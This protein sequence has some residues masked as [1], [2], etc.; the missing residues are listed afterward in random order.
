MKYE[1][2]IK[3]HEKDL[4]GYHDKYLKDECKKCFNTVLKGYGT[5]IAD[6]KR[7]HFNCYGCSLIKCN[8][9]EIKENR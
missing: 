1:D 2:F 7:V 9:C 3:K 5:K 4:Q 6:G 8:L